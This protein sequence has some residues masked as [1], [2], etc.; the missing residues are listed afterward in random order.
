M[1]E[2]LVSEKPRKE[3][4]FENTP[5]YRARC[6][7]FFQPRGQN[8]PGP[9]VTLRDGRSGQV[10]RYASDLL[11]EKHHFNPEIHILIEGEENPRI[12]GLQDIEG[13]QGPYGSF[14]RRKGDN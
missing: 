10:V 2:N 7:A 9:N 8:E 5:E 6:R 11:S 13:F 1:E 14:L 4:E 12:F 3:P